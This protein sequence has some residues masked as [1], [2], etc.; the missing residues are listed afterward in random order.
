MGGLT[1]L[2]IEGF[3]VAARLDLEGASES[4]TGSLCEGTVS[5]GSGGVEESS[6]VAAEAPSWDGGVLDSFSLP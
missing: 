6:A 4:R 2:V 3:V 1:G 5:F